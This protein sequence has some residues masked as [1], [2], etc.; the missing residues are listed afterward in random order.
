MNLFLSNQNRDLLYEEANDLLDKLMNYC[1]ANR[2]IINFDKCCYIEFKPNIE[3]ELKFLGI[4]DNEFEKVEECK[5]L[6]VHINQDLSWND[7]LDSVNMQV[8]KARGSM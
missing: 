7:Q 8:A 1:K 2:L 6:G 3:S 4:N 5:F